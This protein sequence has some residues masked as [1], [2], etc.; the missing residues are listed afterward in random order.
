M[1][2]KTAFNRP[3]RCDSVDL[4]ICNISLSSID[5]PQFVRPMINLSLCVCSI[6]TAAS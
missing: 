6:N 5:L 3:V 2:A 1:R 4:W